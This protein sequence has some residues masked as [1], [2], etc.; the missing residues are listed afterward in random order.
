MTGQRTRRSLQILSALA[1][2][3]APLGC[4][5][6]GGP[7]AEPIIVD[8]S[9]TVFRI[10]RA[11]QEAYRGIKPATL[12]IVGSHG[13]GG[14]FQRYLQNEVDIIDAS[15]TAKP[16]EEAKAKAQAIEWTRF[17]VGYDGITVVVNPKNDFVK[18][19]STDQLKKIWSADGSAATWKDVDPAW[20]NRKIVLYSPDNKS[21]TY[22]FFIEAILGKGVK[23]RKDVQAGADDNILVKGVAA[24]ADAIGYFGYAYFA[25][26]KD[27]LRAVPIQQARG[28]PILPSPETI[29][30]Q[31]YQPLSR[32]LFIYVKNQAM[33][34]PE[35]A[36]FVAYYVNNV[37]ALAEKGGYVAPTE[38]DRAANQKDLPPI[39]GAQ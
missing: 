35:V 9:S 13:T 39:A 29:L 20:P 7:I 4:G 26:N 3:L 18:S 30:K 8:G 28:E 10:S 2:T 38:A 24:D 21:G 31:T 36:D 19:L 12:V 11:A 17:L 1:L 25:A 23:Q 14:G 32:P 16:E 5:G 15:R 27:K 6:G 22:E 33:K 37:A 34:R